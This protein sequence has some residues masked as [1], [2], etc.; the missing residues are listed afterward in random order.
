MEEA[1]ID[2][3]KYPMEFVS[4]GTGEAEKTLKE[5]GERVLAKMKFYRYKIIMDDKNA[6]EIPVTLNYEHTEYHWT[7]PSELKTMK[8]TPPSIEVFKQLGYL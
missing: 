5:T 4:D 7:D 8:L 2:I 6:D 1:G 3:S